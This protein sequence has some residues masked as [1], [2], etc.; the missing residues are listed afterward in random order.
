MFTRRLRDRTLTLGTRLCLGLDPRAAAY[1]DAGQLRA[2]TLEVLAACAELVACVKPQLAFF[3]VLGARGL[4]LLD[5]V[6]ARARSLGLPVLL[7]AK[8]GDVG[9]TAEAYASA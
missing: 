5:E 7:D 6:C 1:H 9:S 4:E 3:E 8:R 2:H